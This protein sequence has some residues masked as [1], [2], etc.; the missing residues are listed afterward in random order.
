[1]PSQTRFQAAILG[2]QRLAHR[3]T[4]SGQNKPGDEAAR[5]NTKNDS[6]AIAGE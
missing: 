3:R 6:H 4:K 2:R 5:L 1:M